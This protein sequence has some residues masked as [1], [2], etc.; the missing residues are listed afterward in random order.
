M[1]SGDRLFIMAIIM[2]ARTWCM[3]ALRY[4][5]E[6]R[7]VLA[8]HEMGKI[9]GDKSHQPNYFLFYIHHDPEL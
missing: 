1:G 3:E 4:S 2:E 7:Y 8:I 9:F 5:P 6:R